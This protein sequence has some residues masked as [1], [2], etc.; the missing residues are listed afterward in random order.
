[1]RIYESYIELKTNYSSV[2]TYTNYLN[3]HLPKDLYFDKEKFSHENI[4]KH[5]PPYFLHDDPLLP[6]KPILG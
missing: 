2:R 1:M 6:K 3:L 5:Y 4:G